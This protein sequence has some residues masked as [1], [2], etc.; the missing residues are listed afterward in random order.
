MMLTVSQV[1]Y[2][3]ELAISFAAARV[4]RVGAPAQPVR[5]AETVGPDFGTRALGLHERVVVGDAIAAILAYRARRRLFVQIGND[6]D[7]L[8]DEVVEPL[9][10]V[11]YRDDARLAGR[12]VAHFAVQHPPVGIAGARE[13]IER[14]LAHGVAARVE[15][16]AQQLAGRAFE[17]GVRR[18]SCRSTR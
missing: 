6:A 7:D 3:T 5:V 17:R 9:R 4:R 12:A 11:A 16:H 1:R 10:V 15:P 18:C 8:A 13:R 2:P 14:D